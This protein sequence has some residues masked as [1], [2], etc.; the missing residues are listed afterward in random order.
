MISP[1]L[2]L[3][4][5][6]IYTVDES[7]PWAEA[8]AI[9]GSHIVAIGDNQQILAALLERGKL[10]VGEELVASVGSVGPEHASELAG[11]VSNSARATDRSAKLLGESGGCF[12]QSLA[13]IGRGRGAFPGVGL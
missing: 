10:N 7:R 5:A 9:A 1:T 3:H 6:K 12:G 13:E 4:N 2:I 8:V 11:L